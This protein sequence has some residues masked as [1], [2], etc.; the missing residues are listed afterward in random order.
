MDVM[1]QEECVCA[2]LRV[3]VGTHCAHTTYTWALYA[4]TILST[5]VRGIQ[6]THDP[7][8]PASGEVSVCQCRPV[9]MHLCIYVSMCV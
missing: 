6:H 8:S 3:Y 2:H 5:R 9:S 4:Y 7:Y 1:R